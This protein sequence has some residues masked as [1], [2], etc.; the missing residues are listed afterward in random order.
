LVDARHGRLKIIDFGSAKKMDAET[1]STP[2][3][4]SRFYRAPELLLNSSSYGNKI[5]IWA[6][7]CVISEILLDA[8]PMF[9]GGNNEEQLIQ[10]MQI[11]GRPSEHAAVYQRHHVFR[12]H[13]AVAQHDTIGGIKGCDGVEDAR[14][15][16]GVE[17]E[18]NFPH[19]GVPFR[20][21][22]RHTVSCGGLSLYCCSGYGYIVSLH[23]Q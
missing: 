17:L 23:W 1:E 20:R 22:A 10:I 2:Y 9:Q 19:V 13:A 11:L 16:V 4:A 12:C 14:L 18:Q 3:I 5:D 21:T 7:G 6:A 8:M 15:W